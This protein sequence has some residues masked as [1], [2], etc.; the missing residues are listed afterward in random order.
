[1]SQ[2]EI[3]NKSYL[4]MTE[5]LR[6]VLQQKGAG[7]QAE[8]RSELESLGIEVNQS[9]ISRGLRKL[10][11]VKIFNPQGEASYKL[12]A[13][14]QAPDIELAIGELVTGIF[15]NESLVVIRTS[16]GSASLL[17]RQLDQ[18]APQK[19][20]GTIAGDDTIFVAPAS[21]NNLPQL[22]KELR[23]FFTA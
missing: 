9:T 7:T 20:L 14:I 1:M 19:I 21:T 18:W 15:R 6:R 4:N 10:G 13:E 2:G 5:A 16:P 12:P 11:A 3:Q 17:A 22:V 8:I 23:D